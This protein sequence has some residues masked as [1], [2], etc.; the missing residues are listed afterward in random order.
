MKEGFDRGTVELIMASWRESMKKLYGTYITKW[1][2]FC[3]E[4]NVNVLEPTLPQIC[5]F[6]RML[7][8]KGFS[9]ASINAA[10]CALSAI[11]PRMEGQSVGNN[12]LVCRLLKG[13]YERNP[14][15]PRYQDIWDIN[16]VFVMFKRWGATQHLSLK[17]LSLKLVMLLLLVSSQWGQTIVN[18]TTEGMIVNEQI[19]FRMKKLLKHN[20]LGEPLD[21]II[22]R[23]FER[24][25]RLCVVRTVK[26][27]LER[28]REL[29][30]H[31]QLLLSFAKPH[32]PISRDTLARWTLKAMD[33]AG[34]DIQKYKSHS[35]R[36]AATSAARR[37]GVPLNL[38]MKRASWRNVESF[39]KYYNKDLQTDENQVGQALMENAVDGT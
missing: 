7:S 1:C 16:P 14:P 10:R 2:T 34:V 37:L 19:V 39:A 4:R 24:C 22:L 18:L 5:R 29:R 20:R 35:T 27:Y 25:K 3:C 9:Y 21:T 11:L 12:P 31:K 28:T 26:E 38:I 15:K 23:P 36:G 30:K 8:D 33:L 6:L 17:N 13:C 32:K